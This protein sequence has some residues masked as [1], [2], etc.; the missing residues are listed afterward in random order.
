MS[1]RTISSGELP[2][3]L[4]E[5]CKWRVGERRV[6]EV[7]VSGDAEPAGCPA[8]QASHTSQLAVLASSKPALEV[9]AVD[10]AEDEKDVILRNEVVHDA[11]V[12]DAE[13]VKGV[14]LAAD[15]LHLLAA[16][17]TRL[18]R[19]FGELFEADSDPRLQRCRQPLERALGSRTE[20]D[21]VTLAQAMS[22]SGLARPRR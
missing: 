19:C 3:G 5:G 11:V 18:A 12:A 14:G 20:S 4:P 15:R 16:N 7:V 2:G 17:A 10:D 21:L 22:R 9:A 8:V 13:T 1:K 6:R